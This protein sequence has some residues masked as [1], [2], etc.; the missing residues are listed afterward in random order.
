MASVGQ[1]R[2]FT[3][4]KIFIDTNIFVYS[5][6]DW[7]PDKKARARQVLGG[8]APQHH[9][10]ISTQVIQELYSVAVSKLKADKHIVRHLIHSFRTLEIVNIDLL[11]IEE[12]IDISL[13]SQLSFWDSLI[14]AAAEKANCKYIYSEDLHSGGIYRGVTVL[15]PFLEE[16]LQF[17]PS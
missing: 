3:V 10:I 17:P 2:N 8:L 5:I 14:V 7:D 15:N 13:V 4:S 16:H 9:S 1:E 6:D 11:L 12:A